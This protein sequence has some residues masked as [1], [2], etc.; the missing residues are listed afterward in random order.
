MSADRKEDELD[1]GWQNAIDND[2]DPEDL[3]GARVPAKPRPSKG[4][5]G[6]AVEVEYI[7]MDVWNEAF[8]AF[9]ADRELVEV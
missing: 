3:G 2:V 9:S 7:T 4:S 6:A 8:P 5:G 1:E